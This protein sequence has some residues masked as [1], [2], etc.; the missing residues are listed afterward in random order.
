[1]RSGQAEQ[2]R[3]ERAAGQYDRKRLRK[4]HA[5]Q[6]VSNRSTTKTQSRAAPNNTPPHQTLQLLVVSAIRDR[7]D[8]SSVLGGGESLQELESFLEKRGVDR[9]TIKKQLSRLDRSVSPKP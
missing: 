8:V 5:E 2:R 9:E 4:Q 1:M 6:S 3:V 7:D